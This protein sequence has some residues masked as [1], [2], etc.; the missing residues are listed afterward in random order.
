M[1]PSYREVKPLG[2]PV[3]VQVRSQEQIVFCRSSLRR[4]S[5]VFMRTK[6]GAVVEQIKRR[7]VVSA[8]DNSSKSLLKFQLLDVPPHFPS[9]CGGW[10][11]GRLH[12]HRTP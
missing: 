10:Y 6:I 5:F 7:R 8:A 2:V 4:V 12:T 11:N 9:T 3:R 1:G